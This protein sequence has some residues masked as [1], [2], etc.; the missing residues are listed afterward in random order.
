MI[1]LLVSTRDYGDVWKVT[2]PTESCEEISKMA[3]TCSNQVYE[4]DLLQI[5]LH[6]IYVD[7]KWIYWFDLQND[8]CRSLLAAPAFQS[9]QNLIDADSFTK[10]CMEDLCHCN[11]SSCLCS[12]ISE[13][14]RQCAHAGG[15]P[16]KWKTSELCGK[17]KI[18]KCA[19]SGSDVSNAII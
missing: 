18:R 16:Q 15:E 9:C 17:I 11:S 14:S 3:E 5:F 13:Y 4:N 1:S 12:T 10:A 8:L 7:I 19:T 6:I 2:G